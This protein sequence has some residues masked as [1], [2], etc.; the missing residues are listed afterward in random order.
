MNRAATATRVDGAP[1]VSSGS[2]HLILD[3]VQFH[4]LWSGD[5]IVP[6]RA[7]AAAVLE[8]AVEDLS[9][10]RYAHGRRRQRKYWQA[11][12]WIT[13]ADREWPYSFLNVCD[14]LNLPA[15]GV[16]VRLLGLLSG[17]PDAEAA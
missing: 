7:L 16:R 11:H 3:P 2:E 13:S 4:E 1:R 17:T 12:Q 6:E 5:R 14:Y 15:E 9:K 10:Y 8:G